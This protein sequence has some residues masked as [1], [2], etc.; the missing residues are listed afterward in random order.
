MS[1]FL[2][3]RA[4][5]RATRRARVGDRVERSDAGALGRRQMLRL[6]G[7]GAAGVAG[8]AL[9]NAL[10]A[11]PA[12]AGTDGDVALSADNIGNGENRTALIDH[13]AKTE[14][15][16]AFQN[17]TSGAAIRGRGG[18]HSTVF[19]WSKHQARSYGVWA[20]S[21]DGTGVSG[22][23]DTGTGVAGSSD[24]GTAVAGSSENGTGV[25]GNSYFGAGVFGSSRN[26]TGVSGTNYVGTGVVASSAHGTG[27]NASSQTGNALNAHTSDPATG[28]AAVVVTHAG[29]GPCLTVETANT[30]NA[31]DAVSVTQNGTGKGVN[32]STTANAAAPAVQATSGSEQPAVDAIGEA[33]PKGGAVAVAGHGAA[34]SVQGV[35]AFTRSGAVT[36]DAS[37]ASVRVPVPGGLTTQSNV[38]ALVQTN[39][40]TIAVRAAVP[41]PGTGT[42]TIYLNATAPAGTKIAWFV[43][44]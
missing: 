13:I 40:G 37:A 16:G 23:S 41:H 28:A 29:L 6:G 31:A 39:T 14:I 26:G 12:A 3:Q 44:G 22:V 9:V 10:D 43:F 15:F 17:A 33:V 18:R 5:A 4:A 11:P 1:A 8:A 21:R 32:V 25:A 42:I 36:L 19:P 30:A 34:L 35:A 24:T 27:V 20:E 2:R 7:M 38:L